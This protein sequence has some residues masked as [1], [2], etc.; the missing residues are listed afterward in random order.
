MIVMPGLVDTH[1]HVWNALLKNLPRSGAEYFPLKDVFGK[2][3]TPIDYYR[4]NRLFLTEALNAGI[5]TVI[6][7]AHNTQSPAHVDEEIRAMRRAGC[8]VAMP[9]VGPIPIRATKRSIFRNSNGSSNNGLDSARAALSTSALHCAHR[10]RW[11]HPRRRPIRRSSA[12]PRIM[13]Y[14]SSC[15]PDFHRME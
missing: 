9:T 3:H 10:P 14:R 15:I 12:S 6:N 8:V 13:A 2:H 5:T 11:A 7:Y 1:S 4:A